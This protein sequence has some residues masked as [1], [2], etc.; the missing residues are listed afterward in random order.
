M[1]NV[2][3]EEEEGGLRGWR[4]ID[5]KRK[6]DGGTRGERRQEKDENGKRRWKRIK[7]RRERVRKTVKT[8]KLFPP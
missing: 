8:N 3:K 4:L 7:A 2:G 5:E 6:G 1:E